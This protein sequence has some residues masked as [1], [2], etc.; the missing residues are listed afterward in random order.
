MKVVQ[1]ALKTTVKGAARP[2]AT[3]SPE[4]LRIIRDIERKIMFYGVCSEQEQAILERRAVRD[5]CRF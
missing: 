4:F 1:D 5:S 3:D 2:V